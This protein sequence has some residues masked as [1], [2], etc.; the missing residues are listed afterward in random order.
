MKNIYR[1]Q[2]MSQE[3]YDIMMGGSYF[4][5]VDDV[6]TPA[7]TMEEAVAIVKNAHPNMVVNEYA[8]TLDEI[9]KEEEEYEAKRIAR[10]KKEAEAKAKRMA[11]ETEPGYKAHRNW[12]RHDTEIRKAREEI[13]RLMKEIEYHEARK[14]EYA[15][16][17]KAETGKEIEG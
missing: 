3:A 10:E 13:A 2:M 11:K 6:D 8:R 1:V 12:K 16:A 5:M 14:A 17:Y 4:Y 7:D 9:K 15:E